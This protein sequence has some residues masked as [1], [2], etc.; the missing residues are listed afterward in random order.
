MQ[1]INEVGLRLVQGRRRRDDAW[2]LGDARL[3]PTTF[4]RLEHGGP[5]QCRRHNADGSR[6]YDCVAGA[7][8]MI[9]RRQLLRHLTDHGCL[10][11]REG[12]KHSIWQNP[13][14]DRRTTV[15]RHREIPRATAIAICRQLGVP[16]IV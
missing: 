15:P 3:Y 7:T 10:L 14:V 4:N 8:S 11:L 12:A 1:R 9:T 16:D 5:G 6:G 2:E 13:R